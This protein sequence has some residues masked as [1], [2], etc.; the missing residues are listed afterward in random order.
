MLGAM[1]EAPIRTKPEPRAKSGSV[2]SL[3]ASL[4]V[5]VGSVN[6]D[7]MEPLHHA[8]NLIVALILVAIGCGGFVYFYFIDTT[9]PPWIT[10]AAVI[11]GGA[12]LY[13]LWEE[14]LNKGQ[15]S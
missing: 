1:A 9:R 8:I 11:V 3:A 6:F 13:W 2:V 10:V 12:G 14:Y 4:D 7:L 15:R 5:T